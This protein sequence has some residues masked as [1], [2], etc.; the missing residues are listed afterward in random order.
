MRVCDPWSQVF[1]NVNP[2][3]FKLVGH[4]QGE[5]FFGAENIIYKFGDAHKRLRQVDYK[6]DV[7]PMC[8]FLFEFTLTWHWQEYLTFLSPQVVPRYAPWQL[9]TINA[10][11][12]KWR[13]GAGVAKNLRVLARDLNLATSQ[14]VFVGKYLHRVC[15]GDLNAFNDDYLTF[16]NGFLSVSQLNNLLTT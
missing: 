3:A 8:V 1:A 13:T 5:T 7:S 14:R 6:C 16:L 10:H 12:D 4:P 2:H 9:E 15:Q 11:L